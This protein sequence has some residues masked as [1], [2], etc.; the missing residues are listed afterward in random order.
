LPRSSADILDTRSRHTVADLKVTYDKAANAAYVYVTDPRVRVKSTRTCPCDP[1][2]VDG[3]INFDFDEQCRVI[4][5]EVL[6]VRSKL[7]EY[8][9]QTAERLDTEGA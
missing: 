5:I 2:D 7:P 8:L 3:M 6:G 1:V 9:L 4:G